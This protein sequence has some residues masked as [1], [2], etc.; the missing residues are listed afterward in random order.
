LTGR[1]SRICLKLFRGC[2]IP[3]FMCLATTKRQ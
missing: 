3:S 1:R 2:P